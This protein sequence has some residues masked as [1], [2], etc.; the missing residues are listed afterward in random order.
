MT[1]VIRMGTVVVFLFW[2]LG[3]LRAQVLLKFCDLLKNP[4][5]YNGRKV[6]IRATYQYGYEWSYLYCLD[7]RDQKVWLDIPVDLDDASQKALKHLPKEAGI[8]NATLYGV[9][10]GPGSYGHL[11][12]F[13]YRFTAEK[14][15]NVAVVYRRMGPIEKER[16]A[17]EQWACGGKDPK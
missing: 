6:T 7:C 10:I 12:G 5:K 15:E 3:N 1:S 4:E 8:V 2:G 11:N 13:R 17:E 14:V 16:A 9:F